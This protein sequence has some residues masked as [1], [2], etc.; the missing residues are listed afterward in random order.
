MRLNKPRFSL[1]NSQST[2]ILCE[3]PFE[4]YGFRIYA[5][6][7]T[8]DIRPTFW[9][10][11]MTFDRRFI[12]AATLIAGLATYACSDDDDDAKLA[13]GE[14]CTANAECTSDYCDPTAKKCAAKPAA[15]DEC[16]KDEDCK[17]VEGKP[18]CNTE[19]KKCEAAP[20]DP[21]C[22]KNEDC[23]D[24]EKPVCDLISKECIASGAECATD[25]DC[26]DGDTYG[27]CNPLVRRCQAKPEKATTCGD[28]AVSTGE[29]CDKDSGGKAIFAYP[30]AATCLAY[31]TLE[32]TIDVSGM[33]DADFEGQVPSCSSDCLGYSKG[34]CVVPTCG[35]GTVDD[36]ETCDVI[37]GKTYLTGDDGNPRLATC[38]DWDKK[39]SGWYGSPKCNDK[40]TGIRQ[41][42][43]VDPNNLK[44]VAS[45]Q[46]CIADLSVS[47][48]GVV[49]GTATVTLAE[50]AAFDNVKGN[51]ICETTT[52]TTHMGSLLNKVYKDFINADNSDGIV[53]TVS[54]DKT[55]T[56]GNKFVPDTT[57]ACVV[58]VANIDAE[59]S[60]L[61][62]NGAICTPSGEARSANTTFNNL[63]EYAITFSVK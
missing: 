21:G 48:D 22:S 40:C 39:A 50:G 24:A 13:N 52:T 28:N 51:I 25:N 61:Q 23:K 37:D 10:F 58:F 16:T 17:D 7:H 26:K 2:R 3:Y 45:I 1:D 30:E 60:N 43:C 31:L 5:D 8:D 9:R 18:V 6:V 55:T 27:W 4:K 33:T 42:S 46:S 53:L 15:T 62:S 34:S 59:N 36:T 41:G 44:P 49:S 32:G 57:Y 38:E 12:F 29:L 56:D 14:K 35:N 47:D 20:V 54:T 19:T 63:L 11:D